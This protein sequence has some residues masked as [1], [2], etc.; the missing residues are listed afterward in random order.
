MPTPMPTPTPTGKPAPGCE[1]GPDRR[2]E[3]RITSGQYSSAGRKPLNQDF[4]GLC[5]PR[6]HPLTTKGIAIAIADG[7]SS[8]NVS[9]IASEAA[10]AGFLS[11][12]YSTPDSWTVQQSA[13]R[14]LRAT[15]AWL[16]AQTRQSRYR[17]DLDRGYVCTFSALILKSATAHV[18][19]VGDTRIYRVAGQRLEQLTTDHRLSLSA[20]QSC[21]TR[22]L[23]ME[24]GLDVEYQ[25]V[26]V[27]PGDLFVLATDGLYDY[28]R[29]SDFANLLQAHHDDL[30]TAA[31]AMVEAALAG[32][33]PDNLTLQLIR[34]E[35]LPRHRLAADLQRHWLELPFAAELRPGQRFD[36]YRILRLLHA[37]SRSHVYLAV[38]EASGGEVVIKCPSTEQRDNSQYLEQFQAE[39]W[40]A[41]R[42][43]SD[44]VVRPH[45]V[46]RQRSYRYLATE[47]VAGKTLKQWMLDNPGPDLESVRNLVTQIARGLRAF[48]RLEMVHG[49]LKPDNIL[50]DGHGT[51]TLIDF[52][53]TRVA[54]LRELA[55]DQQDYWPQGAA[56]YSAPECLLGDPGSWLSDQFGLGVLTYQLLSGQLPY[57][58]DLP[59]AHTLGQQRRLRYRPL[60]RLRPDL[61]A[62]VDPAIARAVAIEPHRRYP[63]LSEWLFDLRQPP[64][65]WHSRP[66]QPLME[67]HPVAFWQTV[68]LGLLVALLAVLAAD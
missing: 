27:R 50:V 28:L 40:V 4:H 24:P 51:V 31:G 34:V 55:P 63:A 57:G 1:P 66:R 26:A 58:A 59:K 60:G 10:V 56:L 61:P 32:G 62:W 33:S 48:H 8:S 65:D 18:F 17:Y 7:I 47:F 43:N 14:V 5:I 68:S 15:N 25:Q 45:A 54:G 19:H 38:D 46:D 39:E 36:G 6:G 42:I 67:R 21:L 30:D 53:A 29:E 13:G 44:H 35:A 22:A 23:G 20:E 52:G 3:L 12:Y 64:T 9:Q 37:S 49:D 41:R 2:A 11:D 16:H